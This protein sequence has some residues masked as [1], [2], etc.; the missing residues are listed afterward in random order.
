[1]K[2]ASFI[3]LFLSTLQISCGNADEYFRDKIQGY[4]YISYET[5]MEHAGTGTLVGGK[6]GELKIVAAPDT[7]FPPKPLRGR[8][9]DLR[10]IDRT[11]LSSESYELSFGGRLSIDV[12]RNMLNQGGPGVKLVAESNLVKNV[13]LKID[14]VEV[15]YLDLVLLSEFY[16]KKMRATCKDFL[17]DFGFIVQALRIGK[18]TLE[19]FNS[20]G[21]KLDLTVTGIAGLV[22]LGV[23]TEFKIVNKSQLVITTPKYVGYQIGRLLDSDYGKSLY[24]ASRTKRGLF[25]FENIALFERPDEQ[26][27]ALES[28]DFMAFDLSDPIS[29][30]RLSDDMFQANAESTDAYSIWI[31]D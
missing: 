9:K 29:I 27:F 12:L 21:S 5:P 3:M 6:P 8:Y 11:T 23:G 28:F 10:K 24:R 7:C 22:D 30:K 13:D 16:N 19:F 18:M 26:L 25:F 4:G 14:D 2:N 17:N 15:E 31:N 1:M 20:Y